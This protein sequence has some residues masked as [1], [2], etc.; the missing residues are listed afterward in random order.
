MVSYTNSPDRTSRNRLLFLSILGCCYTTFDTKLFEDAGTLLAHPELYFNPLF[1]LVSFC[2]AVCFKTLRLTFTFIQKILKE[3]HLQLYKRVINK[4]NGKVCVNPEFGHRLLNDRPLI[5]M[6]L[7][8]RY[9][10]ACM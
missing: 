6:H 10:H 3:K 2:T 9:N 7:Q 5:L 1:G 4:T 8:T